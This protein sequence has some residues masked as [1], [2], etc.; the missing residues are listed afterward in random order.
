MPMSA[1]MTAPTHLELPA[2]TLPRFQLEPE[3]AHCSANELPNEN[4]TSGG[5]A[6]SY[7]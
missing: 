3:T 1:P 4:E 5:D 2:L 6:Q 7:V